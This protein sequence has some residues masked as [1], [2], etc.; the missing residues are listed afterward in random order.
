MKLLDDNV[1]I[2][3][4]IIEKGTSKI[5]LPDSVK[6]SDAVEK[7][8]IV[9][10]VGP[11]VEPELTGKKVWLDTFGPKFGVDADHFLVKRESIYAYE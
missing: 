8:F 7:K 2:K 10:D 6:E 9:E 3:I 4:E 5:I 1:L 11:D